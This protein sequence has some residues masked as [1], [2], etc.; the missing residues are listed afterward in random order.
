MSSVRIQGA[1]A[2]GIHLDVGPDGDL[3]YD[4]RYDPSSAML[5]RISAHE[6]EILANLRPKKAAAHAL[7]DQIQDLDNEQYLAFMNVKTE[8]IA[9][10][11]AAI[12]AVEAMASVI[13]R[14]MRAERKTW[15]AAVQ[16]LLDNPSFKYFAK[17]R[18]RGYRDEQWI[19]ACYQAR[20]FGL[21]A[22]LKQRRV[23]P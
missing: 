20:E 4:A 6:E 21:K 22:P 13:T 14:V 1:R 8:E 10:V 5:A 3:V 9:A 15:A 11:H 12:D 18:P 17:H 23:A 16:W 2:F 7:L 19:L